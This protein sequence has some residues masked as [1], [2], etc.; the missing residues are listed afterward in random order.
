MA[1]KVESPSL[2]NTVKKWAVYGALAML[3]INT[4]VLLGVPIL[5]INSILSLVSN[6][7]INGGLYGA[8]V[9]AGVGLINKT[10]E[11]LSPKPQPKAA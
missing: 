5:Y 8:A 9:G 2:I 7:F 6:S 3:A 4:S 1:E 10:I 11:A